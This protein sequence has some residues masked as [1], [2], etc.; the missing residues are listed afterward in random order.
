MELNP[1]QPRFN[2]TKSTA[3]KGEK[4]QKRL[5]K[6]SHQIFFCCKSPVSK[7]MAHV[8]FRSPPRIYRESAALKTALNTKIILRQT[9]YKQQQ[10]KK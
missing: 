1:D 7:Y 9:F 2:P 4:K 8:F 3:A 6:K 10:Q 5:R